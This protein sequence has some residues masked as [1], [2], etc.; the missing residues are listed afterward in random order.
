MVYIST[1]PN[2][3]AMIH[4]APPKDKEYFTVEELPPGEGMLMIGPGNTL[5]RAP[6]PA[7]EPESG[8]GELEARVSAMEEAIGRGLLL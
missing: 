6:L 8:A 7:A 3:S 1:A 4:T 5:Y 2:G